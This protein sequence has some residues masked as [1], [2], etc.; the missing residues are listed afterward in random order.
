MRDIVTKAAAMIAAAFLCLI[1]IPSPAHASPVDPVQ[2]VQEDEPGWDCHTM[3]NRSCVP[4]TVPWAEQ[5]PDEEQGSPVTSP[6]AFPWLDD[7]GQNPDPYDEGAPTQDE[8][9]TPPPFDMEGVDGVVHHGC[10]VEV[11][12]PSSHLICDDGYTEES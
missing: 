2:Y 6:F 8:D 1:V 12:E 3:G 11:D 10:T 5:Y 4:P 7:V 9:T